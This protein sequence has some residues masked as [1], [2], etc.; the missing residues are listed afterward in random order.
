MDLYFLAIKK[1]NNLLNYIM[2]NTIWKII[3]LIIPF[4]GCSEVPTVESNQPFI[5]FNG[6]FESGKIDGYY[7][8]V[9][10]TSLNTKIVKFPVRKGN[11][12]LKNI[13]LTNDYIYNGYRSELAIYNCAKFK[14]EVFYGFSV[15]ID[16]TYTDNQYNIICQW[17][18]LPDFYKG[19]VWN[20]IP[21][22]HGS[23]PPLALA[24]VNSTL[25]LKMNTNT[26]SSTETFRICNPEII[27][28]NKWYDLIFR[29]YWSDDSTGFVE[30]WINNRHLT[31]FNGLDY[32]FYK[33]NLYNR[34]GNYFKF[35]Q[36][37]GSNRPTTINV[38]YFDEIKIGSSLNEVSP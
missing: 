20:S 18:D 36:Y 7:S 27:Q 1:N 14:T 2:G 3:T 19:E 38:I 33:S 9:K 25:E 6:N 37:R 24:Y 11:F 35:G 21:V 12:A 13:L 10:D 17:Q 5:H 4:M 34:S 16:S 22:L 26:F 8:L 23:P 15:L 28:K 31:E 30:A 32:K 29:I